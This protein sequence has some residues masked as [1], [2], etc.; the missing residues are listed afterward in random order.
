MI[1]NPIKS[2]YRFSLDTSP[3]NSGTSILEIMKIKRLSLKIAIQ[4][5]Q[6]FTRHSVTKIISNGI[7]NG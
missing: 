4:N 2:P 3:L 7:V 5:Q 1:A 6:K